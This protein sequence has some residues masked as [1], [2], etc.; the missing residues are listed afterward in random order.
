MIASGETLVTG[1]AVNVAARLEQAAAPGEVLIGPKTFRL[2]RDAVVA[3]PIEPLEVKGKSEPVAAFRLV[4]VMAGAPGVARRLDSPMVG[5]ERQLAQLRQAFDAAAAD[6]S[7][8]L[9]TVLGTPG[10]GKSRLVEEFVCGRLGMPRCSAG[11]CLPYGDGITFFPVGEVVKE[12]AGLEDFDA[13]EEVERKICAVLGDGE[14]EACCSAR[15]ALRR[16]R[17]RRVPPT[18]RF[19]AVRRFLESV[20]QSA[21]PRRRLR[22]HPLG[23]TDVPRPDRA[24]RGLVA[25]CA[26]PRAVH[27]AT[28]PARRPAGVGRRQA[29]RGHDPAR[30]A[31]RRGVRRS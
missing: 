15:A 7:C 16:E 14:A 31:V 20:A 21:T 13:P 27:G 25:G 29:E 24:H 9:F 3:E 10:V 28:R 26:D 22:R 1:D 2:V 19:W 4:E 12:A 30:A 5:R 18:R 8:Q 23:R 6:R 17:P 11:R